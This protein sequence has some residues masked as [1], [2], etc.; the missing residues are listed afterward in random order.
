M[1]KYKNHTLKEYLECL[2]ARTPVPGG[3]SAAALSAAL[4][5]S[6]ISMVANYSIG[7]NSSKAVEQK[8]QKIVKESQ[9]IRNRL[10]ELVDLDAEVYLKV[11]AT[12]KS[13]EKIK[14]AALLKA[15]QVPLEICRLCYQ[16]LTLTPF[17][18]EKGNKYLLSDV[19]AAVEFLL[20]GFNGALK[21][22]K[23]S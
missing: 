3:G 11:T 2:S 16:A 13:S 17:L 1:K 21:F 10:L 18:V 14:N 19:E 15:R 8:F 7:K 12:R 5:A 23:E 20:A 6:L 9:R 22:T 4:G